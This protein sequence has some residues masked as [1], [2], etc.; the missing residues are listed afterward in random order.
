MTFF[1]KVCQFVR[2]SASPKQPQSLTGF[3]RAIH[4][5][6][7]KFAETLKSIYNGK[8]SYYDNHVSWSIVIPKADFRYPIEGMSLGTYNSTT[9]ET[10]GPYTSFADWMRDHTQNQEWYVSPN[11]PQY[12]Y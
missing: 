8:E 4:T 2:T 9:G 1:Q 3:V 6:R 10:F 11:N 7:Y 5:Y 12:L